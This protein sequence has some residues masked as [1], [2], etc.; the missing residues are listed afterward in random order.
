M[1]LSLYLF[2][3]LGADKDCGTVFSNRVYD[4]PRSLVH[5]GQRRT[6]TCIRH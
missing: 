1:R 5:A 2:A 6:S 4:S 3:P